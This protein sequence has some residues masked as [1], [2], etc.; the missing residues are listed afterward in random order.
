MEKLRISG[1]VRRITLLRTEASGAVV[2]IPLFK[3][4]T[5]KKGTR[6]IRGIEGA[7][8]HIPKSQLKVAQSYLSRHE[9]SN[10]KKKDGWLRDFNANVLKA[11]QKGVRSLPCIVDPAGWLDQ[12][13]RS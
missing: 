8:R 1:S 7:A 6:A 5:A 9:R 4:P 12:M 13:F 11:S 10:R 3:R 2:P